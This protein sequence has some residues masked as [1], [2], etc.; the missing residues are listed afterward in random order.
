MELCEASGAS[1]GVS[2]LAEDIKTKIKNFKTIPFD[3]RLPNQNQTRNCWRKDLDFR[4]CEEAMTAKGRDVSV[5]EWY[6]HVYKSLCP[7]SWEVAWDD[8]GAEGTLPG[9]I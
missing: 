7:M 6:Q 3:C 1:S 8:R 9:K 5:C 2:N 4:H